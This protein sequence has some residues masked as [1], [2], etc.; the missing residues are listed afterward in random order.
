MGPY[1]WIVLCNNNANFTQIKQILDGLFSAVDVKYEIKET[2]HGSFIDGRVGRVIVN[3]KEVAY[4]GEF[5][6]KVL[7]NFG[8]EIPVAVLELNLEELFRL[9]NSS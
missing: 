3:N 8:L 7:E 9:R 1:N 6:P 5:N 4:I 2:E